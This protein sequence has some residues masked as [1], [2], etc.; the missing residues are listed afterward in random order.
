MKDIYNIRNIDT[1]FKYKDF[2]TFK[3][4]NISNEDKDDQN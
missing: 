1:N 4:K 3:N 2:K